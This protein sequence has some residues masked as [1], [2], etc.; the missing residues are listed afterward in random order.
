MLTLTSDS[1]NIEEIDGVIA[2]AIWKVTTMNKVPRVGQLVEVRGVKCRIFRVY[3]YGTIDCQE[4]N[5]PRT[6]RLSGL[7]F[8]VSENN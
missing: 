5:G 6:Y 2:Y 3:P 7:G 4:I 1:T 8:C